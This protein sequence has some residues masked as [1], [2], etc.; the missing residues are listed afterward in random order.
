MKLFTTRALK[1]DLTITATDKNGHLLRPG[2]VVNEWCQTNSTIAV[3]QR[4]LI[5]T[6]VYKNGNLAL[7]HLM[8]SDS[9]YGTLPYIGTSQRLCAKDVIFVRKQA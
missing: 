5:I 7:R 2:N 1:G 9:P 3:S 8:K 6:Q 4:E